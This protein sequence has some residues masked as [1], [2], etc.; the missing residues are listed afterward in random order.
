MPKS[1]TPKSPK[2]VQQTPRTVDPDRIP[3][4]LCDGRFHIRQHN[5]YATL[6]FTHARP[7]ISDL[8]DSNTLVF[9]E[10]VRAR[11]TMSLQNVAQ[12]RDLLIRV[13]GPGAETTAV[14][15]SSL[16]TKH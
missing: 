4:T 14:S 2:G 15:A 12:L 8:F 9:E 5:N 1:P 3:E 13:I 16:P 10:V 7:I 11:I 6:T